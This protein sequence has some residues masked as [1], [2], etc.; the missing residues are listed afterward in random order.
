MI[1]E[2]GGGGLDDMCK[3]SSPAS[4][5]NESSPINSPSQPSRI[6]WCSNIQHKLDAT[7]CI[8]NNSVKKC[9]GGWQ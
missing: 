1:S 5:L 2:C 6:L 8:V 4:A 9:R 7:S 3:V